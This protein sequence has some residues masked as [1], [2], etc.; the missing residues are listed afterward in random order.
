MV[1]SKPEGMSA[2]YCHCSVGYVQKMNE[3]KFGRSVDV[4]LIDSVLMGGKRC[5]FKIT[6]L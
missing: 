2:T 6:V 4:E 1:E 5:K 3:L